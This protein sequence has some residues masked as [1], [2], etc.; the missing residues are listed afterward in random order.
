MGT[1][2]DE[3]SLL[4]NEE[5]A[6]RL[7]SIGET[8]GPITPTTRS[9]YERKLK[10]RLVLRNAASC[11]IA[12]NLSPDNS[13]AVEADSLQSSTAMK[14]ETN[15]DSGSQFYG[16]QLPPNVPQAGSDDNFSFCHSAAEASKPFCIF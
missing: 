6:E 16:V 8:F 15:E 9:Q 1:V 3:I 4:T 11:T 10:R 2:D 7:R 13:A 12:Y 5:L 14:E